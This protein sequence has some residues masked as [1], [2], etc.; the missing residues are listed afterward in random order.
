M[1]NTSTAL[2]AKD[3]LFPRKTQIRPLNI[4]IGVVIGFI[5]ISVILLIIAL[6]YTNLEQLL[7]PNK[8]IITE[9]NSYK[10]ESLSSDKYTYGELSSEFPSEIK[11]YDH[12]QISTY[13][14]DGVMGVRYESGQPADEVFNLYKKDLPASGWEILATQ[15]SLS[16]TFLLQAHKSGKDLALQVVPGEIDDAEFT[17]VIIEID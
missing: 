3:N 1:T 5:I 8:P 17:S 11:I 12:G 2:P 10:P 7:S 15:G 13:N 16:E 9:D 14:Y 6:R 4:F